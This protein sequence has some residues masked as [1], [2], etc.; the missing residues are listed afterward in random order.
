MNG[1]KYKNMLMQVKENGKQCQKASEL[2]NG[3]SK[4]KE[5]V[6][7][8]Y[9][10]IIISIFMKIKMIL[11]NSHIYL[12]ISRP[13]S[14]WVVWSINRT[15]FLRFL[16]NIKCGYYA[17]IAFHICFHEP[18][19]GVLVPVISNILQTPRISASFLQFPSNLRTLCMITP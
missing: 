17:C 11:T 12:I 15:R 19:F 4:N 8:G 5:S 2:Q 13:M 14:T 16:S 18:S 10:H 1:I 7:L 6:K 9:K 3:R